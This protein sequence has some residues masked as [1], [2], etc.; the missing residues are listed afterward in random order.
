MKWAFSHQ[1]I[2]CSIVLLFAVA[3][4]ALGSP[5]VGSFLLVPNNVT[6]IQQD[7]P[8]NGTVASKET[9]NFQLNNTKD[10]RFYV[11]GFKLT[12]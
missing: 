8:V 3:T 11:F 7:I 9:L 12:L 10:W 5:G 1:M 4:A 6:V 2:A